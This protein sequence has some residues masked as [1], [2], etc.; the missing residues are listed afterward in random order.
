MR[1]AIYLMNLKMKRVRNDGKE[2]AVDRVSFVHIK[3]FYHCI[4][5][6]SIHNS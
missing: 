1:F 2:E 6:R 4:Q 3:S 5:N